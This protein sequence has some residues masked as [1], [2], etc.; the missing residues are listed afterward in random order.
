MTLHI[1]LTAVMAMAYLASVG[2]MS[3][4]EGKGDDARSGVSGDVLAKADRLFVDN[5]AVS[6]RLEVEH[7]TLAAAK[8]AN[9]AVRQYAAHL[10][11]AHTA[12]N[13][14][15]MAM[16]DRKGIS[17]TDWSQQ[18]DRRGSIHGENDATT[19]T[20]RGG[21]PTGS[22][23]ATG[24][25]GASGTVATLGEAMERERTG[26]TYPWMHTTGAAFDEGFLATQVKLHQDAIALFD[27]QTTSGADA[28][29]KAFAQR[30]LPA[31]REHLAQAQDL[32]RSMR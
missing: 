1:G 15:L 3:S 25:T 21:P 10:V 19:T 32:Q 17:L 6:G 2:C 22:P 18:E 28:E 11:T 5:A 12:V 13:D 7:A 24:T 20:K 31:L 27:Q 23:S 29:L 30:H 16:L 14:E 9:G 26:M 4:T 8:A